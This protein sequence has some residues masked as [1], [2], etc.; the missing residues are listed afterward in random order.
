MVFKKIQEIVNFETVIKKNKKNITSDLLYQSKLLGFS[1]FKI[2]ELTKSSENQI[3][4]LRNKFNIFP[5]FFKVDTCAG[6]F[7]T[8][9]SYLYSS[10]EIPYQSSKL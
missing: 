1:D 9:T 2:A 3:Y 5:N 7:K 10:Y 8:N 4:K 6:E